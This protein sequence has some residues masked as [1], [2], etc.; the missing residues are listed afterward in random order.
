MM[1]ASTEKKMFAVNV[2]SYTESGTII[3]LK[4][5]LKHLNI[6]LTWHEVLEELCPDLFPSLLPTSLTVTDD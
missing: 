6:A 3:H 1:A 5:A 4:N 2:K